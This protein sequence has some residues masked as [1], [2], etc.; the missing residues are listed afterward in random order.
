MKFMKKIILLLGY[1]IFTLPIARALSMQ[2]D[3]ADVARIES[4]IADGKI[5]EAESV[6]LALEKRGAATGSIKEQADAAYCQ[7]VISFLSGNDDQKAHQELKQAITLYGKCTPLKYVALWKSLYVMVKL[8]FDHKQRDPN[9]WTAIATNLSQI[10]PIVIKQ[11]LGA[12]PNADGSATYSA[13]MVN[14]DLSRLDQEMNQKIDLIKQQGSRGDQIVKQQGEWDKNMNNDLEHCGFGRDMNL[15]RSVYYR[16]GIQKIAEAKE[17]ETSLIKGLLTERINALSKIIDELHLHSG[18][19]ASNTLEGYD[20]DGSRWAYEFLDSQT[21]GNPSFLDNSSGAVVFQNAQWIVKA[22]ESSGNI[23]KIKTDLFFYD[24]QTL[25]LIATARVPNKIIKVGKVRKEGSFYVIIITPYKYRFDDAP[26]NICL[27]DPKN[28]QIDRIKL[29]EDNEAYWFVLGHPIVVSSEGN[30]I[31]VLIDS[32]AHAEASR[33]SPTSGYISGTPKNPFFKDINVSL[34]PGSIEYYAQN[35]SKIIYPKIDTVDEAI[36]PSQMEF[37]KQARNEEAFLS[38]LGVTATGDIDPIGSDQNE[39]TSVAYLTEGKNSG[40][41]LISASDRGSILDLNLNNL[42]SKVSKLAAS[43]ISKPGIFPNG[44]IYGCYSN[45]L[46]IASLQTKYLLSMPGHNYSFDKE[47][48]YAIPS[49]P[50]HIPWKENLVTNNDFSIISINSDGKK[51]GAK[52]PYSLKDPDVSVAVYPEKNLFYT[53]KNDK[54]TNVFE[55]FSLDTGKPIGNPITT[56]TGKTPTVTCI[57]DGIAP[58]GYHLVSVVT[59]YT[60]GGIEYSIIIQKDNSSQTLELQHGLSELPQPFEF[61]QK[62]D[63]TIQLLYSCA[64][65]SKFEEHSPDGKLRETLAEWKSPPQEGKPLLLSEKNLIFIPRAGGYEAY[66]VFGDGKPEKVFEIYFRGSS[67]YVILLPNG[68]YAGSPGCEK[69]IKI[70]SNGRLVDA[71]SLAPWKNRP[72]EVIKA[73]GGDPKTADLLGKVTERWLKRIGF[74]PSTPEPSASEIAKVS[75]TQ[76]PPLWATSQQVS[77]PIEATAGGEPLKE[78]AVRVNGVLQKSFSGSELNVPPGGHAILNAS[79]TLAEGQNWIEVTATDAKGRP[80]NLEHFRTI[81]PKASETPKRYIVAMGCSE[82]DR[83]ELN[84]Q[85]AAKDAGDVL[86]AFQEAGGRECKTLLL[87]NKEVGPEA[88]EKI[89]AFFGESRES[90]EVILF[91]AGHGLLDEHLDYVYAG[92]Q[93]DTEHP[94][95][96]GIHLDALLDA[97]GSGKSLKRLVLMD[98]CQSGS[99]GE[100]EEMKLAQASTELPHGVRAVKSRALKVVG[101]SPLTGDEQQRFIEEM[102]LL[103]GQYRGINIIGASGGAEYAMESDKWNNGVFTSALIEALRDQ[104]ADMDHR[105]RISVS[106]LKTYLAQRVPELTG[107]AQKPS[108]VAFEQDQDFDLVGKMPPIPESVK[109]NTGA[110]ASEAPA[111]SVSSATTGESSSM[112]PTTLGSQ[113]V[114]SLGQKFVPIPGTPVYF[115][116][117]STRVSDYG[118]FVRET[119]RFWKPSGFPQKPDHAAVRISWEDATAFCEWLTQKEHSM[120]KLPANL[121]YRLPKDLEWSAAVGITGEM[122]G[123]PS[124]RDGGIPNCFAWGTT[125]P[126]PPGVGNLDP[127]MKTDPYPYTSPVGSFAPNRFGLYDMC[128]NVLQW[129]QEDFD[130]SGQGFLR[131]SSWPDEEPDGLNLT[132]RH[133]N[134]KSTAYKCYGFRCVIAPI[135]QK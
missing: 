44:S 115:C 30:T 74:D 86:K 67:D 73:L 28:R 107:G 92:H 22:T 39:K 105:G 66:R 132:T 37:D 111:P 32:A 51:G 11:L 69:L 63:G 116:I 8:Y 103:P 112:A 16:E 96:T 59:D 68:F 90:D 10:E 106:D 27:I 15:D 35:P 88:L 46:I 97:V 135:A 113:F 122:E 70:P 9:S 104:K 95:D 84:L 18:A 4:L 117:W 47:K 56:A 75:V 82:Y 133:N 102:F 72:A 17:K 24:A 3:N 130:E 120:G 126:P 91:C 42:A 54:L 31:V 129:C 49:S 40:V 64:G 65:V 6:A 7:G 128:G 80:G 43:K 45:S 108:V 71:T 79:V 76:M 62:S 127:K 53:Y 101:V 36:Q 34:R 98:T 38:S 78:V 19:T 29:V 123:Q 25:R 110:R 109:K 33:H 94:G 58:L 23:G 89:K 118:Q 1:L 48:A 61:R 41:H 87:T 5:V 131:G 134:L 125:W 119:G 13:M 77:F 93:I 83:P 114:N 12:P 124:W 85:F 50:D 2:T 57:R 52:L 14:S 81:L 26:L 99:V 21:S 55:R 100:K 121:E 20:I 60:T